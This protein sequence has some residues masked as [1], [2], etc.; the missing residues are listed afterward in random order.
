[1]NRPSISRLCWAAA[2]AGTG[3][4]GLTLVLF[5][6]IALPT[7]SA[8]GGATSP[9]TNVPTANAATTALTTAQIQAQNKIAVDTMNEQAM[10]PK[11]LSDGTKEFDFTASTFQWALYPGKSEEAWGVNQQVPGPV[12]RVKVG[13]KVKFVVHNDLPEP[14][15][16]H[17]HGLAVPNDMDGVPD[18][19]E[20]PISPGGSFTYEF[21][22]T[23]QMVGT[24]WYHSHYDDDLQVDSGMNG[25][26]IVD[27][28]DSSEQPH[29]DVDALFALGAT[30]VDGVDAEDVFTIDG[31][32]YPYAP[33][34]TVNQG[35]TVLLRLVNTS[36]ESY[37]AMT[38]DG[39]TLR[40]VAEDGQPLPDPQSVSVVSIAPSET[41]DV[42]F[43]ADQPGDWLFHDTIE[44]NLTNPDDT[45]DAMGGAETVIHVK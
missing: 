25:V 19:P 35:Q 12:I 44:S 15:T 30:K 2:A 1:M 3:L 16:I 6:V 37:H 20:P 13:D 11:I 17:W 42:A 14:T 7:A 40:I 31:K 26:I 38:L 27:P 10:Q 36:G 21:T 34:L 22:V 23:Q 45:K 8:A 33:E 29:Y 32:A 9:S 41:V 28:A 24:H 39:Y 5:G 43:T 18:M 4:L